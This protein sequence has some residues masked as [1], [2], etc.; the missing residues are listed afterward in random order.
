MAGD[1][2][3]YMKFNGPAPERQKM[4]D[5]LNMM[6]AEYEDIMDFADDDCCSF[7]NSNGFVTGHDM[8]NPKVYTYLAIAR[9][10][11]GA[12]WETEMSACYYGGGPGDDAKAAAEFKNGRLVYDGCPFYSCYSFDYKEISGDMRGCISAAVQIAEG[13]RISGIISKFKDWEWEI[14]EELS[15]RTNM[16]ICNDPGGKTAKKAAELGIPIFS[17]EDIMELERRGL[18]DD[19]YFDAGR[20]TE[21]PWSECLKKYYYLAF[22]KINCK[23]YYRSDDTISP[24]TIEDLEM[25]YWGKRIYTA[26]EERIHEQL[27]YYVD[28]DGTVRDENGAVD[29]AAMAAVEALM[30]REEKDRRKWQREEERKKRKRE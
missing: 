17:E 3:W 27:I 4:F 16:L 28:S 1:S 11:P 20:I 13:S 15:D 12:D 7:F 19:P 29:K 21:K 26:D 6:M 9:A 25:I 8:L 10:F 23:R 30:K 2:E 14:T 22:K 5:W 18:I 24:D